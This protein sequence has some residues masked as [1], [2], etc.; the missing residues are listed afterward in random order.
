MVGTSHA[1]ASLAVLPL[2]PPVLLRVEPHLLAVVEPAVC[3]LPDVFDVE[4]V[5][6][7]SRGDLEP[8]GRRRGVHLV[9]ARV[10]ASVSVSVGV[11]AR[12]RVRAR[13]SVRVSGQGQGSCPDV[14]VDVGARVLC[15]LC[16][17]EHVLQPVAQA[18]VEVADVLRDDDAPLHAELDL[19]GVGVRVRRRAAT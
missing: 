10:S 13:V 11:R 8:F 14:H 18:H 17:E 12:V 9:R 4:E 7:A 16:R 2:D 15:R 3:D 19:V 6:P 1:G 5:V